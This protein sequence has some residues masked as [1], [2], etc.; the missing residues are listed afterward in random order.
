MVLAKA[1]ATVQTKPMNAL[2]V[3]FTWALE[4]EQRQ[5]RFPLYH[6]FH[7]GKASRLRIRVYF[8]PKEDTTTESHT[9]QTFIHVDEEKL[10]PGPPASVHRHSNRPTSD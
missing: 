7:R 6:N 3:S 10:P 8:V 5:M 9:Q 4:A 1:A 2:K